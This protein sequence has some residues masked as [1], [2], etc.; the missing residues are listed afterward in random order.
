MVVFKLSIEIYV[1]VA[2]AV[3]TEST[4]NGKVLEP[5]QPK[6][7]ILEADVPLTPE[8]LIDPQLFEVVTIAVI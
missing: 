4:V 3:K 2:V 6:Y 1:V 5:F 7:A 8:T